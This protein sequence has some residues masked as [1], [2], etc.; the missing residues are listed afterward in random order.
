[1]PTVQQTPALLNY[2]PLPPLAQRRARLM[3]IALLTVAILAFHATVILVL[4][5]LWPAKEWLGGG[6]MGTPASPIDRSLSDE[7][8]HDAYVP[9]AAAYLA[10]FLISQWVFLMPR[11]SWRIGQRSDDPPSRRSAVAAGLIGMLLSVGFLATLM[12]IPNWWLRLTTDN[13]VID[14]TQHFG[15]VWAVMAVLWVFWA[16]IFHRHMRGLDR[17]TALQKVFRWLF[18]GTVIEMFVAVPAHVLILRSRGTDCYCERGT[19]TGVAFGCTAALWLFGPGV[20]LLLWRE[21]RRREQLL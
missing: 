17:Q 9:R 3:R 20:L 11:G 10:V 4:N 2:R 16:I 14:S 15:P 8:I 1:M 7:K 6:A 18:A 21:R 5:P 12:E 13:G 19:W